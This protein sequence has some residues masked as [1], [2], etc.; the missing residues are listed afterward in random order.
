MSAGGTDPNGDPT[1]PGD[2]LGKRGGFELLQTLSG[3][4]PVLAVLDERPEFIPWNSWIVLARLAP[5][6]DGVIELYQYSDPDVMLIP[7]AISGSREQ[8]GAEMFVNLAKSAVH[9]TIY[10]NP[11]SPD[12]GVEPYD[13]KTQSNYVPLEFS[14]VDVIDLGNGGRLLDEKVTALPTPPVAAMIVN[15]PW[16]DI[17]QLI[18]RSEDVG[19]SRVAEH[20]LGALEDILLC[21]GRAMGMTRTDAMMLADTIDHKIHLL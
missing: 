2:V 11:G 13:R 4:D 6:Y 1:P 17:D 15:L 12:K 7:V 18:G 14:E 10:E 20:H 19:I 5:G 3:V 21:L 9:R 8:G 16:M